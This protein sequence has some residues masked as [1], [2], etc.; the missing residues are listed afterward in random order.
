MQDAGMQVDNRPVTIKGQTLQPHPIQYGNGTLVR[1]RR[2]RLVAL[3]LMP[4]TQNITPKSGSWNVV[5][6]SFLRPAQVKNWG[7]VI[8]DNR[9][10]K[11]GRAHV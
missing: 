3:A 7:V 8:F 9:A 6:R 4:N 5:G 2:T 10:N 1:H 11:I